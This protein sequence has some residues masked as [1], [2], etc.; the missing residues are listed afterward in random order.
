[1]P[2][3]HTKRSYRHL[4]QQ[5]RDRLQSLRDEGVKQKEIAKILKVDPA[6]ISR[7]LKRKRKNGRYDAATAQTKADVKRSLSKHRGMQVEDRPDLKAYIVRQLRRKRSPDEIAGRMRRER[8]PFY[9]SKNAIYRWL[10][11]IWGQ[12]Y[13]RY[14]C[15]KRY[16]SKLH[17]ENPIQRV[18]I[19]NRVGIALRPAGAANKSRYGHFEG[20]TIVAPKKSGNTEA[21]AIAVDRKSKLLVGTRIP[22]LS[23]VSMTQA[24]RAM[25]AQV[26][27]RSW[28]LDNGIENQHHE[29]WDAPAFFCDPHAPAQK[30]VIEGSIGLLRRWR[31]PKGTDWS[32]VSEAC[33]QDALAFLNHK[34]R[35]SLKYQ[36]AIEVAM[37]HGSMKTTLKT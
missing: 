27:V 16:R 37:A 24:T 2:K 30:P 35:K 6:T 12:R 15:T 22:N 8:Q 33:L 23:P 21:V 17:R 26:V 3:H 36:S 13:C 18:M 9:A 10:Y 28:T 5:D 14:L 19:P 11:S 4:D 1:M 25:Q 31:F 29:R 20:D 32:A 7:E 34:Y